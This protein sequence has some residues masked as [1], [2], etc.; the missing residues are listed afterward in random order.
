M[1]KVRLRKMNSR[2]LKEPDVEETGYCGNCIHCHGVDEKADVCIC[3]LDNPHKDWR[4]NDNEPCCD[5]ELQ[6]WENEKEL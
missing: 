1:R 6:G 4:Y 5:W 2:L 3:E